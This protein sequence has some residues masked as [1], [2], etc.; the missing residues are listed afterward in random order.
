MKTMHI[1]AGGKSS[2]MK[3][4]GVSK[5]LL[6]LPGTRESILGQIVKDARAYFDRVVIWS[7]ENTPQLREVFGE[8][9]M[10]DADMTGPLGP[11][12][13]ALLDSH[14]R[15]Y[16]CAGDLVC[17]FSW[18]S[19]EN[20]HDNHDLP[21]SILIAPSIPVDKGARFITSGAHITGWERGKTTS[22][23]LINIGAYI[24][25]PTD[26]VLEVIR[27]LKA[28]EGNPS[29]KED[30][31]FS[32]LIANGLLAGYNPGCTCYNVND[33]GTYQHLKETQS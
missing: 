10:K 23:D 31:F 15:S 4:R 21:A 14:A 19:F 22:Q 16:G 33:P 32:A 29:H 17:A 8:L 20:F 5:H 24:M 11:P 1:S 27:Q 13:R 6:P 30:Q 12:I 26:Q 3:L 18:H 28:S 9:V 25:D 2:R 7:G